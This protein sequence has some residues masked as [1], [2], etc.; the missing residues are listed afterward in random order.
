MIFLSVLFSVIVGIHREVAK[1]STNR[2]K[3]E[4]LGVNQSLAHIFFN[5]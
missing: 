5:V 1:C 2:G 3:F 4:N